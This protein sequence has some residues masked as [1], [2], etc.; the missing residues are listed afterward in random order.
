[1]ELKD[2]SH[3]QRS[4]LA[5]I[6][7]SLEYFGEV[8]RADLISR[9]QTGLA[10]AT[11]D[12][13]SYKQF[14]PNNA[15]LDH[16]ARRYL[17]R[18]QFSPLFS[19]NPEAILTGLSHGFGDGL[20][21]PLEPSDTCFDAVRLVHPKAEFIAAI[22]RAIHHRVPLQC[23]YLSVSSGESS[24][25]IVPHSLVNNG[26]RWHVR[27]F[28]RVSGSFRDFVCT[29]FTQL[30]VLDQSIETLEAREYDKQWN[31]IVELE[32]IAHPSLV[33]P[34]AIE[35]DYAMH[36]GLLTLEVRAA[37]AGYLLR[38]WNVD[39]STAHSLSGGEYQLALKDCS[40]LKGVAGLAIAPGW[41]AS[42]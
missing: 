25:E 29:R 21:F 24:R 17:R 11:R 40:V 38:Q 3:G 30:A 22:M 23:L 32:L 1:M 13:S 12:L 14:A 16:K 36:N 35:L 39:C 2:L 18:D 6:D 4:R 27:A 8:S 9:F 15:F 20:S 42:E 5:F 34:Q 26:H 7:F 41:T 37:L 28:D 10:A 19:H 33:H 31:H